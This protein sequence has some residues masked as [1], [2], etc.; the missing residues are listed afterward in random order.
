LN[1]FEEYS[2]E[3]GN[4]AYGIGDR[5]NDTI[6]TFVERFAIRELRARWRTLNNLPMFI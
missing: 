1:F 6:L 4:S 3:K 5:A 2:N